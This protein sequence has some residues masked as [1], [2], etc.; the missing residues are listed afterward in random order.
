[1]LI[2][3]IVAVVVLMAPVAYVVFRK[4]SVTRQE[5]EFTAPQN[6]VAAI[7]LDIQEDTVRSVCILYEDG[8]V[9]EVKQLPAVRR[10]A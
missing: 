1:M 2:P 5:I 8:T 6:G 10:A 9:G 7:Y 3:A 4:Y